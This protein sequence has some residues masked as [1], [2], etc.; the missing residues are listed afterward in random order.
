MATTEAPPLERPFR[1]TDTLVGSPR[2]IGMGLAPEAPEAGP[3]PGGRAP[4]FGAPSPAGDDWAFRISGRLSAFQ[5]VGIGREPKPH[6]PGHDGTVLHAPP[7]STGKQ[8]L[9]SGAGFTLFSTY[10]NP[11]VAANLSYSVNINGVE[12]RGQYSPANGPQVGQAYIS[13]SPPQFGQLRLQIK[14]GA[15]T[16]NYG[17]VGQW[18]W[19]IYGPLLA[20]RGFGEGITGEVGLN[21]DWRLSFGQGF[22]GVPSIPENSSRGDY[23]G[24]VEL[25]ASS[26]VHHEHLGI[27]FR[28]NHGLRLHYA[29]AFSADE[30][31]LVT[32]QSRDGRMD[33]YVADLRTRQD[34]F[35]HF[36][37]AGAYY[38]IDNGLS[39]NDGIWW[40]I[41]WTQGAS[42]MVGK[43]LGS[44]SQGNGS[45]GV[46]SAQ[47]DFSL[48]RMLWHPRNYDG[49]APDIRGQL[50]GYYHH[51][52]ES[53]DQAMEGAHGYAFGAEF[54]YVLMS[55]M[56]VMLK[57]YGESREA[58]E[59]VWTNDRRLLLQRI[60]D[61]SV[62]S[63]TP[64]FIFR[65]DWASTDSIQL[66]YSR[67][68]YSKVADPNPAEPLDHH[69]F[70]LGATA[71][72]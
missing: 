56:G 15:F 40:G 63:I 1:P 17:G 71:S 42:Q 51:T 7:L 47:W 70:S 27:T 32:P 48:A 26:L 44:R 39:V 38:D 65:T 68:F 13:I 66:A 5:S 49:R 25:A 21:Q 69:V 16:E 36:A 3:A 43:F 29:S 67:R 58:R 34:P 55:F 50:A 72:F 9:W 20:V 11:Y 8:A 22:H 64:G 14:V 33:V 41:D 54:E 12:R 57:G 35:G 59:S 31:E 62:Y 19:G 10:G 52:F 4:S 18:G 53:Q 28:N 30:R 2:P 45:V 24:W 23:S 37:V 6:L 60:G 61:Y 46:L